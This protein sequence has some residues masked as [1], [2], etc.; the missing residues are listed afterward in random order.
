VRVVLDANVFVSG[1]INTGTP[2]SIVQS[3]LRRVDFEAVICPRLLTE[4]TTVLLERPKM[5][6]WIDLDAAN[7]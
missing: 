1:A 4:I 2:H 6:R 3:W 5:R 7:R